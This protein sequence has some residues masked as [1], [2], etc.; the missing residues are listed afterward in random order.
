MSKRLVII[1]VLSCSILAILPFLNLPTLETNTTFIAS[2]GA[3]LSGTV[4]PLIALFA[5]WAVLKTLK[6]QQEQI[7]Q[8]SNDS[9]KQEITRCL[10]KLET[11]VK[12]C[13]TNHDLTI[14][15]EERDYTLYQL[16][17][18]PYFVT[19]YEH[20]IK[21]NS[22]Y[23]E[24][25]RT[26]TDYMIYES[27]CTASLYVT[28]MSEYIAA[29]K[30]LSDDKFVPGFYYNKYRELAK[31][32]HYLGYLHSDKYEFWEKKLNNKFKSDSQR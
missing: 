26:T 2:Y 9:Q 22:Y 24:G 7:T 1:C 11:Q 19:T 20:G 32:L 13:L 12:E 14:K 6:Y 17:T 30:K 25:K 4:A 8:L 31:R 10:E 18:M 27:I 28:R 3:Y 21:K 15:V 5:F 23:L 16:M 29:Y